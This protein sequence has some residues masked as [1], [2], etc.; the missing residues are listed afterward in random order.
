VCV[1]CRESAA[2]K[3]L[4]ESP[5][6][7]SVSASAPWTPSFQEGDLSGS[8][9]TS[10]H[11]HPAAS[12]CK[13]SSLGAGLR[14]TVA[15]YY[16][17]SGLTLRSLHGNPQD[18]ILF[19][20]GVPAVCS[21]GRVSSRPHTRVPRLDPSFGR[22]SWR[23]AY[24]SLGGLTLMLGLPPT[25]AHVHDRRGGALR[26]YAR[27]RQC[28]SGWHLVCRWTA[29]SG[30]TLPSPTCA[31]RRVSFRLPEQTPSLRMPCC[32]YRRWRVQRPTPD[33]PRGSICAQTFCLAKQQ[34]CQS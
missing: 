13:D 18:Q 33:P 24:R 10:G 30:R 3:L 28:A 34:E 16:S 20:S 6:V 7:P 27:R 8:I 17:E 15:V 4:S 9:C 29:F 1:V 11:Q 26:L 32:S 22:F 25:R 2:P 5:T 23:A 21:T 12:T 31:L 19:Q 14:L